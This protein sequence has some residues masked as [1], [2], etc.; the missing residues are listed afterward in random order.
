ME[1]QG[2]NVVCWSPLGIPCKANSNC[3]HGI[4]YSKLK[5]IVDLTKQRFVHRPMDL[6]SYNL[7]GD[8]VTQYT[9]IVQCIAV[10]FICNIKQKDIVVFT[11]RIPNTI[12]VSHLSIRMPKIPWGTRRTPE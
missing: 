12:H 4:Y 2:V 8:V 1:T 3:S 11:I 6:L 5:K 7:M 10:G 9:Y